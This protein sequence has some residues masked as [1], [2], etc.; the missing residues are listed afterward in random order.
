ME[1]QGDSLRHVGMTKWLSAEQ[2]S[3]VKG[4]CCAIQT[5]EPRSIISQRQEKL[6]HSLLVISGL[7]GRGIPAA[8]GGRSYMV[9]IQ[10]PGDFVDLHSFPLKRLDHDVM[11]LSDVKLAVFKHSDIK[12]LVQ[13]DAE[14]A[15]NLWALTLVDASIHRHWVYRNSGMRAFANVANL[16]VELHAR[17]RAAEVAQTNTFPFPLRQEDIADACGLTSVHVN[18]VLRQLRED[19]CCEI[20]DGRVKVL[21]EDKLIR[22]A[23]FEPEYLYLPER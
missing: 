6:D 11:A 14:L 21:D 12:D 1:N 8:S 4:A 3:K 20:S 13:Q 16:I 22:R 17:L 15:R 10:V 5:H 23:T 2:W 7:I 18:R 19:G 9:A